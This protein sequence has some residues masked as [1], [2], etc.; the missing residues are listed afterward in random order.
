[1]LSYMVYYW[2]QHGD[3]AHSICECINAE[4]LDHAT[5]LTQ[6]RLLKPSFSCDSIGKGRVIVVTQHIQYVEIEDG[7]CSVIDLPEGFNS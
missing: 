7:E 6:E 5:T 1:M 2:V 3:K 4:N